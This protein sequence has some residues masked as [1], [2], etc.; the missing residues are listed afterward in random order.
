MVDHLDALRKL[1][2][3]PARGTGAGKVMDSAFGGFKTY[4]IRMLGYEHDGRDE[5]DLY[6]KLVDWIKRNNTKGGNPSPKDGFYQELF[7]EAKNALMHAGIDSTIFTVYSHTFLPNNTI[8]GGELNACFL[9]YFWYLNPKFEPMHPFQGNEEFPH[10]YLLQAQAHVESVSWEE[11]LALAI[12]NDTKRSYPVRLR[13]GS[14][15]K[16]IGAAPEGE[17]IKPVQ[18]VERK[19]G[20]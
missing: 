6:L 14:P 9:D 13:Y 11:T 2:G 19:V 16:I 17:E 12:S 10:R 4:I 1:A 3:A 20:T 15:V 8:N 5:P 7:D 18:P